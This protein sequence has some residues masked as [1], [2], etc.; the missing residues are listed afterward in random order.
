MYTAVHSL[1]PEYDSTTYMR[2][3]RLRWR[4]QRRI[5]ALQN[6]HDACRFFNEAACAVRQIGGFD[7][8]KAG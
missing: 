6:V 7:V 8:Q 1:T 2:R 3:K 5:Y 4:K